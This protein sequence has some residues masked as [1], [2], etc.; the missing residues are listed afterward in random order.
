MFKHGFSKRSGR[1]PLYCVWTDIKKRCNNHNSKIYKYYGERGIKV[2]DEWSN[3]FKIFYDWSML[4]GYKQGL[5]ID[6]IDNDKGYS[7]DNCRFVTTS[8]NLRNRR[9]RGKSKFIG[10]TWHKQSKKW[11]V[12]LGTENG[13]IGLGYFTNEIEAA[14]AYNIACAKHYPNNPEF[15][16][17]IEG[18]IN[19]VQQFA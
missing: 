2:C 1:H 5:E 4:N 6:R 16:N 14:R 19:N 3:D 13:R 12:R 15:L 18:V 8:I 9:G 7:P 17:K 10:V 11:R